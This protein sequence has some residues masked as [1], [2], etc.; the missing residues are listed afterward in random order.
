MK[1]HEL[2]GIAAVHVKVMVKK[3]D[4]YTCMLEEVAA[5]STIKP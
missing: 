2:T 4:W 1:T 3:V 5:Y